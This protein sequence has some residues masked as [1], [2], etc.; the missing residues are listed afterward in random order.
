MSSG[1][2]SNNLSCIY[3]LKHVI[4]QSVLSIKPL[5]FGG[6]LM[7]LTITRMN[8]HVRVTGTLLHPN[9]Q[10]FNSQK[11]ALSSPH[12]FSNK[13]IQTTTTN[14]LGKYDFDVDLGS[15]SHKKSVDA[16]IEIHYDAFDGEGGGDRI[17]KKIPVTIPLEGNVDLGVLTA[18]LFESQKDLPLLQQP[19]GFSEK[20]ILPS[21][22]F[23]V[24]IVEIAPADVA[25]RLLANTTFLSTKHIQNVL[26]PSPYKN[27]ELTAETTV[28]LIRNG[29]NPCQFIKKEGSNELVYVIQWP[30]DKDG[31]GDLYD[32]SITVVPK[33]DTFDVKEITIKYGEEGFKTYAPDSPKFKEALYLF[34]SMALVKGEAVN[35]LGI[36][37]LMFGQLA[38]GYYQHIRNHPISKLIGPFFR[39]VQNINDLGSTLI[40]GPTG[41]I[42]LSGLSDPGVTAL[43]KDTLSALCYSTYAPRVA[44]NSKDTFANAQSLFWRLAGLAVHKFFKENKKDI[45]SKD[46]WHEIYLMSETLVEE[47]LPFRPFE[48]GPALKGYEWAD[49]NEIDSSTEDRRPLKDGKGFHTLR[50]ITT[51][52]DGPVEGDIAKL[53]RFCQY[54]IFLPF[55]HWYMHSSQAKWATNLSF[56]S[57]APQNRGKGAFGST[58]PKDAAHQLAVADILLGFKADLLLDNPHN[59]V[60]LYFLELIKK[61]TEEFASYGVDVNKIHLGVTI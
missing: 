48:G 22:E 41:V 26:F 39:G 21:K 18:E 25:K 58:K 17:I 7:S 14:S 29:I 10:P 33:N 9:K 30:Y 60:Y 46:H 12:W 45:L 57:L 54:C 6:I 37:H 44:M 56:A 42:N 3:F 24:K 40:F 11:I 31:T 27:L 53:K 23:L 51:S 5:K 50:P 38:R 2:T 1:L 43:I 55:Y 16:V 52:Q 32:C 28:D 35:H 34:N 36:G 20:A 15:W 49:K 59:D 47:S 19:Q 61:H 8:A 13:Q 4:T